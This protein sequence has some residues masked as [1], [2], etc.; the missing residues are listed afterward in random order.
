[1]PPDPASPEFGEQFDDERQNIV[2]Y[3]REAARSPFVSR[4]AGRTLIAL[5]RDYPARTHPNRQM[6]VRSHSTPIEDL[7]KQYTRDWLESRWYQRKLT[8]LE[9][10]AAGKSN[11]T[12]DLADQLLAECLSGEGPPRISAGRVHVN[13]AGGRRLVVYGDPGDPRSSMSGE[14]ALSWHFDARP[15]LYSDPR[16]PGIG[17]SKV[18]EAYYRFADARID[19]KHI[20][21]DHASK[22]ALAIADM[23]V[24]GG[25][26]VIDT[27]YP[28]MEQAAS[29]L[30]GAGFREI[31]AT[32]LSNGSFRLI[33]FLSE[34]SDPQAQVRWLTDAVSRMTSSRAPDA[35]GLIAREAIG[36]TERPVVSGT[37][38]APATTARVATSLLIRRRVRELA[39]GGYG[40]SLLSAR[41]KLETRIWTRAQEIAR[42]DDSSQAVPRQVLEAHM[43]QARE[44]ILATPFVDWV[45]RLQEHPELRD[46]SNQDEDADRQQA[47][48]EV[49]RLID[50][51]VEALRHDSTQRDDHGV[52]DDAILR[53]AESEVTLTALAGVTGA[54]VPDPSAKDT[55]ARLTWNHAQVISQ[56]QS[57]PSLAADVLAQAESDI[58]EIPVLERVAER[59]REEPRQDAHARHHEAVAA[60]AA[61]IAERT[62]ALRH[63]PSLRDRPGQDDLA[64]QQQARSEVTLDAIDRIVR[65]YASFAHPDDIKL[66][67]YRA[68]VAHYRLPAAFIEALAPREP[69][70]PLTRFL[71][72]RLGDARRAGETTLWEQTTQRA[73]HHAF[74]TPDEQAFYVEGVLFNLKGL[75]QAEHNVSVLADAV[76]REMAWIAHDELSV[77]PATLIP[78]RTYADKIAFVIVGKVANE[79]LHAVVEAAN[80]RL[81]EYVNTHLAI[82]WTPLKDIPH[83]IRTELGV[84][85]VLSE[86]Q[87]L[88]LSLGRE[89]GSQAGEDGDVARSE[90]RAAGTD[91]ADRRAATPADRRTRAGAGEQAGGRAP[92]VGRSP[93]GGSEPPR[94]R[95][96]FVGPV[97]HEDAW[98]TDLARRHGIA[99]S[100]IAQLIPRPREDSVTGLLE[101]REI[102][103]FG[104]TEIDV[105]RDTI[106]RMRQHVG[107]TNDRAFYIAADLANLGGVNRAESFERANEHYRAI[108]AIVA[109]EL[110]ATGAVVVGFRTGGDEFGFALVGSIDEE[111]IEAAIAAVK[112]R[113]QAYAGATRLGPSLRLAD[114][115]NP[116][117]PDQPGVGVHLGVAEVLPDLEMTEILTAAE[118]GID[119]SK[120]APTEHPSEPVSAEVSSAAERTAAA[121]AVLA[122]GDQGPPA[123]RE[124]IAAES[125]YRGPHLEELERRLKAGNIDL[126]NNKIRMYATAPGR[127]TQLAANDYIGWVLELDQGGRRGVGRSRRNRGRLIA[128]PD[129][130]SPIQIFQAL[131]SAGA[132]KDLESQAHEAW[133][134]L[135]QQGRPDLYYVVSQ[136]LG[137]ASTGAPPSWNSVLDMLDLSEHEFEIRANGLDQR[138]GSDR[139]RNQAQ[140]VVDYIE[141]WRARQRGDQDAPPLP[142]ASTLDAHGRDRNNILAEL[143]ENTDAASQ[144][145]LA[146][147][148]DARRRWITK[149][150]EATRRVTRDAAL[151][152]VNVLYE[153][154]STV[155]EASAASGSSHTGDPPSASPQE[156]HA[157]SKMYAEDRP[158]LH[159]A[160]LENPLTQPGVHSKR[161]G[162]GADRFVDWPILHR[163]H[164]AFVAFKK[165]LRFIYTQSAQG[166]YSTSPIKKIMISVVSDAVKYLVGIPRRLMRW[167]DP[168]LHRRTYD[169]REKLG[170]SNFFAMEAEGIEIALGQANARPGA[171]FDKGIRVAFGAIPHGAGKST[172]YSGRD[173]WRLSLK[174]SELLDKWFGK[175]WQDLSVAQKARADVM[176]TGGNFAKPGY[177]D[178]VRS[179]LLEF[180]LSYKGIGELT[181]YKE[182]VTASLPDDE[183]IT[184][185]DQ[186]SLKE[187]FQVAQETGLVL[188]IHCDAGHAPRGDDHALLPGATD[189]AHIEGMIKLMEQYPGARIIWAHMAGHGRYVKG[190]T[191]SDDVEINGET[192]SVPRHV[193]LLYHMIKRLPNLHFDISWTDVTEVYTYDREMGDALVDFIIENPERVLLGTDAVKPANLPFYVHNVVAAQPLLDAIDRVD[194]SGHASW[195]LERGNYERLFN[196]AEIDVANWTRRHFLEQRDFSKVAKLDATLAKVRAERRR[197]LDAVRPPSERPD[198]FALAADGVGAGTP[199]QPLGTDAPEESA[200]VATHNGEYFPEMVRKIGESSGTVSLEDRLDRLRFNPNRE[201]AADHANPQL[202]AALRARAAQL[203]GQ[204]SDQ[205]LDEELA[206][207]LDVG[208][209]RPFRYVPEYIWN[210]LASVL[211]E[212]LTSRLRHLMSTKGPGSLDEAFTSL[213]SRVTPDKLEAVQELEQLRANDLLSVLQKVVRD[214]RFRNADTEPVSKDERRFLRKTNQ[215]A[216]PEAAVRRSAG[217]R[218]LVIA[219]GEMLPASSSEY[220]KKVAVLLK[221]YSDREGW[222]AL[223]RHRELLD[224]LSSEDIT[225]DWWARDEADVAKRAEIEELRLAYHE[226]MNKLEGDKPEGPER[227]AG[228]QNRRLLN[229]AGSRGRVIPPQWDTAAELMTT[230]RDRIEESSKAIKAEIPVAVLSAGGMVFLG[231]ALA[232]H[233]AVD[234]SFFVSRGVMNSLR[235]LKFEWDRWAEELVTEEGGGGRRPKILQTL[236]FGAQSREEYI[237]QMLRRV[238]QQ[239]DHWEEKL[240]KLGSAY[241]VLLFRTRQAIAATEQL[242]ADLHYVWET[243]LG[244]GETSYDRLAVQSY[245]ASLWKM[246]MDAALGIQSASP[247]MTAISVRNRLGRY[248]RL[249]ITATLLG[250][251]G[252]NLMN[253]VS[254]I[255]PHLRVEVF[256]HGINFAGLGA[257]ARGAG[258]LALAE[259][260]A[261][262]LGEG[263][264]ALH[265]MVGFISGRRGSNWEERKRWMR[266]VLTSGMGL[267]TAGGAL[268]TAVD[269]L[270]AAKAGAAVGY[271]MEALKVAADAAL[272]VGSAVTTKYL[273]YT[274]LRLPQAKPG[275]I[276]RWAYWAAIGLA[277]RGLL[278]IIYSGSQTSSARPAAPPSVSPTPSPTPSPHPTPRPTPSPSPTPGAPTP[279]H[280][281]KKHVRPPQY[282]TIAQ[283]GLNVREDPGVTARRKGEFEEGALVE[284]ISDRHAAVD[285]EAW[286]EVSGR[287]SN[288]ARLQGWVAKAFLTPY[289]QGY[290]TVTVR[291]GD[292]MSLIALEHGVGLSYL[293]ALNADHISDPNLLYPGAVLYIRPIEQM[294][295]AAE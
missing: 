44:E 214:P 52:T 149:R 18:T 294:R 145:R 151:A 277:V 102:R 68:S 71:N 235:T 87:L 291:P 90:R 154:A 196:G 41:N 20:L 126:R 221:F 92:K 16:A 15:H 259:H 63:D 130:E 119:R 14:I 206:R 255:S 93:H 283:S 17:D 230:S 286:I 124:L 12:F 270:V 117:N 178:Y 171:W 134:N 35:Q 244:E 122:L 101:A 197:L 13:S 176:I 146:R 116:K 24:P 243:P 223:D 89:E 108:V 128:V 21:F 200:L 193:G 38:G 25:R 213:K 31:K 280:H 224:E 51:R 175:E 293:K 189:Y 64:N 136:D 1:M 227:E 82:D 179:R 163:D 29:K 239:S 262:A 80:E 142:D 208:R 204:Q 167:G 288:G 226:A 182:Y 140:F 120:N 94:P 194:P 229:I 155:A 218:G 148:R 238:D 184:A 160:A 143:Q 156:R 265:Y 158:E 181:I 281:R 22:A 276:E 289:R 39:E 43:Q 123:A 28:D 261:F 173:A 212:P 250:N 169:R 186:E 27:T 97:A 263:L 61:R 233:P 202:V 159:G 78:M 139:L 138:G 192:R 165:S 62:S 257:A 292:T 279:V 125:V 72:G 133:A 170:I 7:A 66:A 104:S 274:E 121:A 118:L 180:P 6:E 166:E 268:L 30:R 99:E 264:L 232:G 48:A 112:A 217:A 77:L 246:R 190:S 60:I 247:S 106:E 81:Q 225:F 164:P 23:L 147:P 275:K 73:Q 40:P 32:Q 248:L 79:G 57:V 55:L 282:L 54:P 245:V 177:G 11:A 98:A 33:G 144:V 127:R 234:A 211:G 215:P 256:R 115:A 228:R 3:L 272:T 47:A 36:T 285:G 205:A 195:L 86:A 74:A 222:D 236:G 188:L 88:P 266:Q 168:H 242:R 183:K 50:S 290:L 203:R 107:A 10:L 2:K 172:H 26:V 129:E 187:V 37:S 83:P 58:L 75:N 131:R 267:F 278:Q 103:R 85:M 69:V 220:T 251:L 141:A 249:G 96:Q 91:E 111:Q 207:L 209:N 76:Y 56:A 110:E 132:P 53:Q 137:P 150:E 42:D 153:R 162:R 199:S 258:L 45:T 113:V 49:E 260:V 161:G 191:I 100:V 5:L 295:H 114:I 67:E 253:I 287:N 201:Q 269:V 19:G 4:R 157:V 271:A 185:F 254:F 219:F 198:A 109:N 152:R 70:D 84:S 95:T 34:P 59:W 241:S 210:G 8:I 105:R 231:G 174:R 237:E 135:E 65:A 273:A 216:L 252:T 284:M 240:E 46:D 9:R